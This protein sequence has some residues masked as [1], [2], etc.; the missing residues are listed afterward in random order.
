MNEQGYRFGVGVLVVASMVI[1]VILIMFFGAAP[2]LF[3]ERYTVTIRFDAAPG[4]ATDTPV[5]KNGVQIGRVKSVKLLDEDGVDLTLELDSEHRVLARELPRIGTGSLITGD[6][7][8][9]FIPHNDASL[10]ARFDTNPKNGILD[11]TEKAVAMAPLKDQ[12]FFRGG[13]VAPSP[14][15]AMLDM[16]DSISGALDSIARAGSS[17]ENAGNQVSSLAE[18]ARNVLGGGEGEIGAVAAQMKNTIQNFNLTL[19]AIRTVFADPNLRESVATL[20]TAIPTL[21]T[22]AQGALTQTKTT[23]ARFE[24]TAVNIE[25]KTIEAVDKVSNEAAGLIGNLNDFTKPFADQ[26]D[27]FAETTLTALTDLDLLLRDLRVTS[28]EVNKFANRL[29]T[30]NGS[31]ARLLDDEQLYYSL[32]L[33]VQEIAQL[34]QRLRPILDDARVFTDKIARDPSAL[35]N[36][37][38]AIRGVPTGIGYK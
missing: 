17:I 32:N 36:L 12:D 20:S 37:R 23:L 35:T 4:V 7:V 27:E 22:E 8:V 2:D 19:E 18:E 14:F 29:N 13:V 1:A 15:D 28:L 24:Q 5:R 16:N 10:L 9:E 33:T 3:S 31:L 6:A 38:G 30:S 34:T 25:G 11:E 26:S 21:V